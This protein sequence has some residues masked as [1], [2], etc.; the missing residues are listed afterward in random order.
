MAGFRST[1]SRPPSTTA[2]LSAPSGY[3]LPYPLAGVFVLAIAIAA[4]SGWWSTPKLGFAVLD[5]IDVHTT[6]GYWHRQLVAAT[7]TAVIASLTLG[8]LARAIGLRAGIVTVPR[9]WRVKA[10]PTPL[11]GSL[12][13]IA[14]MMAGV[15]VGAPNALRSSK[16]IGA[17]V[18][19]LAMAAVGFVDDLRRLTPRTRLLYTA[20]VAEMAW[21][22]GL[23]A[24]A[25]PEG[26][27][28]DVANAL[29]TMLW[30]VGVT[31]AFNV[32]DNMD[33]A[34]AGVA[35][36]S[37]L[38]IAALAAVT[39]QGVLVVLALAVAGGCLGYLAHNVFPARL[40]MGDSGA[41]AVGFSVAA[42]GLMLEPPTARPLG[43]ALPVLAVAVPI[44]DTA[45]VT[46]SRMRGRRRVAIGGTDHLT[47][48]LHVAGLGV[49]AVP[50]FLM[51]AQ[52]MLGGMAMIIGTVPRTAGWSIVVVIACAGVMGLLLL[53]RLPEWRPVVEKG[54][55]N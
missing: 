22:V 40:Y 42:L 9:L 3:S 36:A 30:F 41:L 17:G 25:F 47:H 8:L 44:F 51:C 20:I 7:V 21:V 27:I 16:L 34:S 18:G 19:V 5:P 48:R 10:R 6:G 2:R 14:G 1:S 28:G 35:I 39:N 11:L 38:S 37:S 53:L 49:R 46:I 13:I 12:A 32:F 31:H 45:L 24:A 29:L 15:L 26:A 54:S 4:V 52:L 43:F 23:R 50:A 55:L 33:G